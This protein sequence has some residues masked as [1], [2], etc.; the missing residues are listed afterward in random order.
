MALWRHFWRHFSRLG[1]SALQP[2]SW[3]G[4]HFWSY[5]GALEAFLEAFFSIGQVCATATF[6]DWEAFLEL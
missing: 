6:M 5:N 2:P 4:R 1:K 3:I